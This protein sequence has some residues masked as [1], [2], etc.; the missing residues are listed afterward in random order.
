MKHISLVATAV[1]LG[2]CAAT[3]AYAGDCVLKVT[4]T[5]CPGKEAESYKKC[6]GKQSCEEFK[7]TASIE[8]C[9]KETLKACDN[10]GDRQQQ[11]KSKVITATFDGAPVEG[12]K[13]FCDANRPDFNLC[14]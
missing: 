4:R 7:E 14:K 11:T 6:D 9:A 12:G 8:A 2:L 5:A 1:A 10:V 13:N 3:P